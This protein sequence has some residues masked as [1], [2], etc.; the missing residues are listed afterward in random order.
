M[1]K[2]NLCVFIGAFVCSVCP[3]NLYFK[4]EAPKTSLLPNEVVT[5]TVSAWADDAAV[6]STNGLNY[7]AFSAMVDAT[8]VVEVVSGSITLLAPTPTSSFVI[9]QTS[10]N[11][12]ATGGTG[13]IEYL[14]VYPASS[15]LASDTGFGGYDAIATFNIKAIGSVNDSVTYTL[16]ETNA[17]LGI[18]ADGS[19]ILDGS[20]NSADSQRIFTIVPEPS[21]I[22][23]LSGLS[24][25]GY[26]RRTRKQ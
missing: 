17:F 6:T 11:Q 10:V 14:N 18:L 1:K 7:W 19:T 2:I 9:T 5:V 13:S 22:L 12:M 4:M 8:G 25:L 26:V 21:S 24:V 3:A 23:I 20:F 15:P 16:G